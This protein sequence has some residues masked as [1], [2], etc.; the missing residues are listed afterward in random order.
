MLLLTLIPQ[1]EGMKSMGI[2]IAGRNETRRIRFR[3]Q[4]WELVEDC[5]VVSYRQLVCL[6]SLGFEITNS[7]I[8]E[9]LKPWSVGYLAWLPCICLKMAISCNARSQCLICPALDSAINISRSWIAQHSCSVARFFM[10]PLLEQMSKAWFPS[11]WD[12]VF[13]LSRQSFCQLEKCT[14]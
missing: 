5:G 3:V 14:R 10:S 8:V 2:R 12:S 11:C 4:P 7:W 6:D 1:E 9:R 13:N